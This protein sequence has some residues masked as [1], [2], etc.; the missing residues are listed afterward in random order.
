MKRALH[1]AASVFRSVIDTSR[2]IAVLTGAGVSAESGIPTFRGAGGLWRGHRAEELATP[3]AFRRDPEKVWEWYR[4]R[5]GIVLKAEPNAAH[6]ALAQLERVHNPFT[7]ITQNVDGLHQRA[8]SRQVVELHGNIHHARCTVC[9]H[10]A[11]LLEPT[12]AVGDGGGGDGSESATGESSSL[13]RCQDCGK[14]ARP[15]IVWFGETLPQE[16]WQKA[17]EA[18][19]TAAVLLVVGTSAAVYPAAGLVDVTLAAGGKVIEINPEETA[20]SYRVSFNIKEQAGVALPL[21]L[22]ECGVEME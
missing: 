8:G 14:L 2:P 10:V 18:A 3:E 13:V 22:R 4:W 15:H 1:D 7:L 16:A 17:Y 20:M 21:L 9:G 12:A 19:A 6:G 11:P 5:R